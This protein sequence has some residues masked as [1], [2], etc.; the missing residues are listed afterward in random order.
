MESTLDPNPLE[1]EEEEQQ[2]LAPRRFSDLSA[3]ESKLYEA[4]IK[5][6]HS[7]IHKDG[8]DKELNKALL[9]IENRYKD[10]SL[11]NVLSLPLKPGNSQNG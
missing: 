2:V 1:I 9:Q 8:S 10:F 3:L 6:Q 11:D 7:I 4:T 5:S